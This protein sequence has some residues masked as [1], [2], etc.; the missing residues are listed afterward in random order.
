M[1]AIHA[2]KRL[3][4]RKRNLEKPKKT[5]KFE[6]DEKT[7]SNII[8]NAKNKNIKLIS[9]L[10]SL[11]IFKAMDLPVVKFNEAK[12]FQEAKKIA[13]NIGYPLVLKIS[14]DTISHKTDVNGVITNIQNEKELKKEWQN[15]FL[16][17]EKNKIKNQINSIVVM[18]QVKASGRELVAGIASKEEA[19]KLAMFG[20]GG[21]FIETLKEVAFRPCPLKLSDAEDLVLSTKAKDLM[22]SVRGYKPANL[23]EMAS[24][25]LKLSQL[26]ESFK[27]IA[28]VDANPIMIDK[29]GNIALVDARIVLN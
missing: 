16:N 1:D 24:I 10:D 6:F 17:L 21:I 9:T 20:I 7:I 19:G 27:D 15:L 29:N 25:L 14:S 28:E 26:V 3:I 22:G 18:E 4:E 13:K 11:K 5:K 2:I 23:E 8:E 12:T